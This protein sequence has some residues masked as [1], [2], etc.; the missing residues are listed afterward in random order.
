M[1][2]IM[3]YKPRFIICFGFCFV[4][5]NLCMAKDNLFLQ[6]N[7]WES[8]NYYDDIRKEIVDEG[9]EQG[10][11]KISSCD[12][13]L[14]FF[15]IT[16]EHGKPF[17]SACTMWGKLHIDNDKHA[18]GLAIAEYRRRGMDRREFEDCELNFDITD[19][20]MNI[21]IKSGCDKWCRPDEFKF[22]NTYHID[23]TGG[24]ITM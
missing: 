13:N 16:M 20:L 22:N 2:E 8:C 7:K 1:G 6:E 11:I 3:R 15:Q 23:N 19:N 9:C 21:S 5:P 14:C 10:K 12:D 24:A 17:H 18:S 4:F